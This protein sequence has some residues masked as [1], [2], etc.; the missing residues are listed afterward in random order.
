MTG[1]AAVSR[2]MAAEARPDDCRSGVASGGE[3]VD[4]TASEDEFAEA[5]EDEFEATCETRGTGNPEAEGAE[6]MGGLG[7]G[8]GPVV[9]ER[10]LGGNGEPSAADIL[11]L[12]KAPQTLA[13]PAL[14]LG[15]RFP[16]FAAV[17]G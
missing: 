7:L 16:D 5:S 6:T 10:K 9:N 8:T 13:I 15:T 3:T 4:G 12:P 11:R 14:R 2:A 1:S 17:A